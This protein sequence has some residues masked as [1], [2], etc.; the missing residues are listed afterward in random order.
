MLGADPRAALR[1]RF[2]WPQV[3]RAVGYSLVGAITDRRS[4][5][6]HSAKHR[7]DRDN[8]QAWDRRH[9]IYETPLE[10]GIHAWKVVALFSPND[11][12]D[13]TTPA[14]VAFELE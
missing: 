4:W 14:T 3:P 12:G 1:V 2:E 13:F 6:V 7:V 8:A 5:T 11:R 10:A 9:V